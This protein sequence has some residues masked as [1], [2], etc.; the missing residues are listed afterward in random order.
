MV[1][2]QNYAELKKCLNRI[3]TVANSIKLY[4]ILF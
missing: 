1:S 4:E 2:N 3:K